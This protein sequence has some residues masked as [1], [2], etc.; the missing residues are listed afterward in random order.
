MLAIANYSIVKVH[1]RVEFIDKI[2]LSREYGRRDPS[3]STCGILYLQKLSLTSPTSGGG[4]VGIARSRT[5]ATELV[6]ISD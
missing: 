5:Q 4:S 2:Y 1:C 3:R 6:K